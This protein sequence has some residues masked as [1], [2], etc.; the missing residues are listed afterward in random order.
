MFNQIV[1]PCMAW[2]GVGGA[3]LATLASVGPA[4]AEA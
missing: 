2:S 1:P 3:T 4:T